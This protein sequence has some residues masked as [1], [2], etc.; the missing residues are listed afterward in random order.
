[1]IPQEL[2][3]SWIGNLNFY[4]VYLVILLGRSVLV[5]YLVLLLIVLLRRTGFRK[6]VF[7]KGMLWCL[8]F[9]VLFVGKLRLFYE[10]PFLTRCFLWW[11]NFCVTESWFCWIYMAGIVCTSGYLIYRRL[12]LGILL[13]GAK[14]T[15]IGDTR[16][17]I[18]SKPVTPFTTGILFP[19]IV[20]PEFM[21]DTYTGEELQMVLLHEKIHIRLGHL[22]LY[23]LWDIFCCLLWM[24][25]FLFFSTRFFQEDLEHICD[26][27]AI[28]K[29]NGNAYDYGRLLLKSLRRL[30]EEA[31]RGTAA[32][33]GEHSY[34]EMKSR[35]EKVAGFRTYTI[36]SILLCLGSLCLL[37]SGGIAGLRFA[38]YPVY[39]ESMDI[40]V[41]SP[42]LRL[43]QI[44]KQAELSEAI[45]IDEKTVTIH[46]EA[47]EQVLECNGIQEEIY[48]ISFGGYSKLPGIGGGGNIV[49][50]DSKMKGDLIISHINN[51]KL[52]WNWVI[53]HL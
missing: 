53:K 39:A 52:F 15:Y 22:W 27:V 2:G 32:F 51:D 42:D 24:N 46:R 33:V 21:Q 23:L 26:R 41:C 13:H 16:V 25:P 17:Y 9:P 47:W 37:L 48:Y 7:A 28:Q 11:H 35:I 1:M 49:T 40:T 6:T 4:F 44:G 20:V 38:S 10:H 14:K 31:Q 3:P 36:K 29:S 12:R 45:I 50:V 19:K 34:R 43:W 8:L 5:S 18:F 30:K